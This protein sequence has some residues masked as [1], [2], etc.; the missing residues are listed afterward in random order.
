MDCKLLSSE[1]TNKIR[2]LSIMF[3]TVISLKGDEDGF[4]A[5]MFINTRK[6][7]ISVWSL[8]HYSL[9][10]LGK[11]IVHLVAEQFSDGGF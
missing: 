9:D 10:F 8:E 1:I 2:Q 3:N 7:T 11:T 5:E 4:Y 6:I